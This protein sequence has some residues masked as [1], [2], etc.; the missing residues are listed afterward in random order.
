MTDNNKKRRI[1]HNVRGGGI[2][3]LAH[4]YKSPFAWARETVSNVRDQAVHPNADGRRPIARIYVSKLRRRIEII[5]DL[6]GIIDFDDFIAV[7]TE[8]A[9]RTSGKIVGDRISSYDHVDPDI[10][11]N[12]HVGKLSCLAACIEGKASVEVR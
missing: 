2:Y 11:G 6:T 10:G 3:E 1:P 7:G 8:K 4:M 5:D 12:K 9:Y